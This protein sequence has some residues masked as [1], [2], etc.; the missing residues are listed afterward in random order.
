MHRRI[1]LALGTGLLAAS[2]LAAG[3]TAQTQKGSEQGII[4]YDFSGKNKSIGDP[5]TIG[6]PGIKGIGDPG[7]IGDPNQK[8]RTG[9]KSNPR[10]QSPP[11]PD[12]GSL[13][14]PD[15][16]PAWARAAFG[17]TGGGGGGGGGR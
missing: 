6:D 11:D 9:K 1:M 14:G 4:I 12:K 15:T 8:G 2:G 10:M 5:N 7:L 13:G 3:A 17:S 16:M